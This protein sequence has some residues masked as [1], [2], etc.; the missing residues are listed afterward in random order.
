MPRPSPEE[1]RRL[2]AQGVFDVGRSYLAF[3]LGRPPRYEYW[4]GY[5]PPEEWEAK[6]RSRKP[7]S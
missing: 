4:D 1:V 5:V 3:G 2:K 6:K 7:R